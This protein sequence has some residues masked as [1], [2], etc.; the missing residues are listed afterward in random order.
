MKGNLATQAPSLAPSTPSGS[1]SPASRRGRI[2]S[3]LPCE[4]S[5]AGEVARRSFSRRDGGGAGT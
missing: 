4:R 2:Y 5:E 1:P 3:I